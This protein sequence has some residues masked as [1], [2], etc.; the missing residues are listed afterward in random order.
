MARTSAHRVR[1]FTAGFTDARAADERQ[2]A[3][4]LAH[5]VGAEHVE[6]DFSA[7]DFWALLPRVA[8][9]MD[10]PAADYAILPTYKLAREAAKELKVVLSGEGG[11]E[12]FAGYGRYRRAMRPWW[13]GGRPMRTKGAFDGLGVLRMDVSGWRAGVAAAQQQEAGRWRSRLQ[14]AQAVDRVDW[15]PHDL[16]T[17]LDRCLMAHGV[18]GRT[19]FLDPLVAR[20]AC[21]LPDN[22][23]IK[24]QLGKWLLRSWLDRNCPAARA[25]DGKQGFTVPVGEWI[26]RQGQ[27]VGPLVARQEGIA[28]IC[29]GPEVERLF[30]STDRRAGFAAWVLLF[31]A[32]WHRRHIQGRVPE[33]DVFDCLRD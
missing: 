6:V 27:R 3:R 23:K 10:D 25:F 15:L 7:Q 5:S 30:R 31:Y 24:G 16:L 19:P 9:A 14:A 13:L 26:V 4:A 17:K 20:F 12:Q 32:L 8:A 2:A 33:G 22:L 28:A 18:E 29:H 11:D 1:A 21:S